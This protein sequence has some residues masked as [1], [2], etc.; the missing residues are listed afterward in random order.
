MDDVLD[1]AL[2]IKNTKYKIQKYCN[3]ICSHNIDNSTNNFVYNNSED[4]AMDDA[5]D[6]AEYKNL[7]KIEIK[8][9]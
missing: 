3:D 1:D 4:D 2:G 5:M 9:N 6:D 8:I 7:K